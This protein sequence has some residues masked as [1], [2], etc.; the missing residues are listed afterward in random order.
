MPK[1][2]RNDNAQ[3]QRLAALAAYEILDTPPEAA[4]DEITELAALICDVPAAV[5]NFI[6]RDRQWFKSERGLGIRE[7]PLDISIC[8]HVILQS[9]LFV[10]PDIRLDPRFAHFPLVTGEP[11][12]RFYAGALLKSPDGIPIGTLCVLDYQPR[13]LSQKQRTA[14]IT[15]ANQ[16]MA[17]LE[18]MRAH[19]AQATLIQELQS[20]QKE[21]MHLASTD[22]LTGLFN[23]RAMEERLNQARAPGWQRGTPATLMLMDLDHFKAINDEFGHETG[24]RVI[25]HFAGICKKVF[26][27]S[28]VIGRWGGEEFIVL[29]PDTTEDEARQAAARLHR[30]LRR[31]PLAC[32]DYRSLYI[33]VSAGLCGLSSDRELEHTLRLADRL[34]YQAKRSGRNR[35]VYESQQ[36]GQHSAHTGIP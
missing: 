26:R 27:Q 20:A 32:D 28:D 1:S 24:D 35:T 25:A 14:L 19:R 5:I 10:V 15:L 7:T 12:L 6:D 17:N 21:L 31:S 13:E 23:R 36:D 22:P 4:F 8:A 18:L 33:T 30:S 11:H 34:L 3:A 9:E 29:L 2:C 16:V